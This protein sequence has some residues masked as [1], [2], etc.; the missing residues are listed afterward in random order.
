[1][2]AKTGQEAG[3]SKTIGQVETVELGPGLEAEEI[4]TTSWDEK[5]KV[6][7]KGKG[8]PPQSNKC[9]NCR[10]EGHSIKDC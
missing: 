9:F 10:E 3:P 4:G 6:K 8:M 2:Y 1:M 7:G 5:K